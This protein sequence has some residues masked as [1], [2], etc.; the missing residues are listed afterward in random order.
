MAASVAAVA[1]EWQSLEAVAEVE[2]EAGV[3]EEAGTQMLPP[4]LRAAACSSILCLAST[5]VSCQTQLSV[6]R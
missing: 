4:P 2:E 1:L 5:G 6:L 3:A